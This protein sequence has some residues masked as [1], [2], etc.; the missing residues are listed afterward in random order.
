[1][2]LKQFV[3]IIKDRLLL[4]YA[5]VLIIILAFALMAMLSSI[6]MSNIV[7]R[8][9]ESNAL[10]ALDY[11]ETNIT[12]DLREPRTLLGGASETVRKMI[13]HGAGEK[14]VHTYL[15]EITGFL[16]SDEEQLADFDGL[17]GYFNVFDG[18][19]QYSA[20]FWFI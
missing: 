1:M 7:N 10:A 14:E 19:L 20:L 12:V 3:N 11:L 6:F 5:I 2:R 18:A 9:L 17:F 8:Q 16:R 15:N 4:S 13:L